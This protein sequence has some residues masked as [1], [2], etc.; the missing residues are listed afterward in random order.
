MSDR[1]YI[2]TL[3]RS[4]A[5]L[6]HAILEDISD[7]KEAI[8]VEPNDIFFHSIQE[9][10]RVKD[11]EEA[12]AI[13]GS[14]PICEKHWGENNPFK[15]RTNECDICDY[16][17][18]AEDNATLRTQLTTLEQSNAELI[19]SLELADAEVT[20]SWKQVDG[21]KAEVERL[22]LFMEN[23]CRDDS[24]QCVLLAERDDLK[25]EKAKADAVVEAARY[26]ELTLKKPNENSNEYFE[27]IAEWFHSE[28]GVMAPGN[29][30]SPLGYS[31]LT[32]EDREKAWKSWHMKINNN[33]RDAL[34]AYRG[35]K[36]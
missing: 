23:G 8:G 32:Y 25:A 16:E 26:V 15:A 4:L 13:K 27:R 7:Y 6:R 22:K 30:E 34:T 35:G 14:I 2:C 19:K 20:R 33:L 12:M 18:E 10:A 31:G 24:E 28:T 11:K 17:A 1:E 36:G 9:L 3:E 21:L 29:S 5:R